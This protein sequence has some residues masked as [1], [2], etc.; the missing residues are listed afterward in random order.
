MHLSI[1]PAAPSLRSVLVTSDCQAATR[2]C[3]ALHIVHGSLVVNACTCS[4]L[5]AGK[6]WSK[7]VVMTVNMQKSCQPKCDMLAGGAGQDA[8]KPAEPGTVQTAVPSNSPS[9]PLTPRLASSTI[10]HDGKHI[11]DQQRVE[12]RAYALHVQN[13]Y[14]FE[15]HIVFDC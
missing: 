10:H 8:T 13:C 11:L 14:G 4:A 3:S 7:L 6:C 12:R 5:A 1:K 2:Y 15:V 9:L